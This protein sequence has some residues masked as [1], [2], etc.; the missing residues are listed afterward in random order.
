ME[1]SINDIVFKVRHWTGFFERIF[2]QVAQASGLH[3]CRRGSGL[4]DLSNPQLTVTTPNDLRRPSNSIFLPRI[5]LPTGFENG[6]VRGDHSL[7]SRGV[8]TEKFRA[9]KWE[10]NK[11]QTKMNCCNLKA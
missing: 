7:A 3:Q 2:G 1:R 6:R 4:A 10:E 5:F 11:R 9:E 8:T